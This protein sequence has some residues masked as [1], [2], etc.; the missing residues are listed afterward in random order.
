MT[1]LSRDALLCR[2]LT[3]DPITDIGL[4]RVFANVRHAMLALCTSERDC[5]AG[6]LDFFCAV[7]RQCFL[8]EYVYALPQGEADEAL[9]LQSALIERMKTAETIPALWPITVAAYFPL[10]GLPDAAT[11]YDRSWPQCVEAV[12]VQQIAQPA[13]ERRIGA[14]LP[15]LTDIAGE[16]SRA[17]REQYEENPYPRWVKAGPPEKHPSLPN[18][19]PAPSPAVLIAGCGTGLSTV[20]FARQMRNARIL[21]VDLSV[22]S[23][24]A[25]PSA[26]PTIS[27]FTTSS[28]LRPIS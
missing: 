27:A 21:A 19:P 23:F 8:N 17:V 1:A 12:L 9:K 16:V 22:A 5:D 18:A 26:W 6:L 13:E 3:C 20:E 10:Y 15:A 2:L 14:S 4:E 24:S 28:S 11:L 7:A 25:T